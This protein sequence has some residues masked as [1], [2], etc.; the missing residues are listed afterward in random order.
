MAVDPLFQMPDE[1]VK[2]RFS[3]PFVSEGQNFKD[4]GIIPKGIYN[5]Y[6]PSAPGSNKLRITVDPA[7]LD[8]VA[9]AETVGKHNLTVRYGN[10]LELD[11][12]GHTFPPDVWVVLRALYSLTPE[13]FSGLTDAKILTTASPLL[14]DIK[15]CRVTG[16]AGG[17]I[18]FTTGPGDRDYVGRILTLADVTDFDPVKVHTYF[19][20]GGGGGSY[21]YITSPS[22]IPIADMV[23]T[24]MAGIYIV[25]MSVKAM[26]YGAS[27]GSG[28]ILAVGST[29]I[30]ESSRDISEINQY[31]NLVPIAK[32]AVNGSQSI[33]GMG[34]A[35]GAHHNF[36]VYERQIS[37]I[38]VYD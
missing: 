33:Y 27:G 34:Q 7:R 26:A 3:E 20:Q 1:S 2:L 30:P 15:I 8:S 23:L 32:V 14:T 18:T 13:P 4:S 35:L 6:T 36:R 12:T 22:F 29:T 9:V 16:N 11:F 17:T 25:T 31:F 5:G 19:A 28:V 10:I 38:K 21:D 37:A 24:P